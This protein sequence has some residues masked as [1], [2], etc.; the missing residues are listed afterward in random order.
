[1]TSSSM[2]GSS[3][4]SSNARLESGGKTGRSVCWLG[5]CHTSQGHI[6]AYNHPPCSLGAVLWLLSAAGG[7]QQ[8]CAAAAPASPL[9]PSLVRQWDAFWSCVE[10]CFEWG[11]V[12]AVRACCALRLR[13]APLPPVMLAF[14][15]VCGGV[16]SPGWLGGEGRLPR[17]ASLLLAVKRRRN[18]ALRAWLGSVCVLQPLALTWGSCRV[19]AGTQLVKLCRM[20]CCSGSRRRPGSTCRSHRGQSCWASSKQKRCVWIWGGTHRF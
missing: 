10:T 20:Q 15:H 6:F 13:I 17:D 18:A 19:Q 16:C 5:M 9:P 14:G 1:M 11:C 2:T 7:Q 4:T 8:S 12:P 3:N